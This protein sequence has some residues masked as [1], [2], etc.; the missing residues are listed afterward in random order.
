MSQRFK[1]LLVAHE[2]EYTVEPGYIGSL[3]V[4]KFIRKSEIR[5]NFYCFE[6]WGPEILSDISN[7]PNQASPIYPSSTVLAKAHKYCLVYLLLIVMRIDY[8]PSLE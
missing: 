6:L 8:L 7:H 5:G 1:L 4:E 2:D 3:Q